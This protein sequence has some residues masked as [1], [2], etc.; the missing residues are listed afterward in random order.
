MSAKESRGHKKTLR[1]ARGIVED[2]GKLAD[3]P[4]DRT[5]L[6]PMSVAIYAAEK[7]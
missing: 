7:K 3:Y 1:R 5:I 4:N 2:L 6:L